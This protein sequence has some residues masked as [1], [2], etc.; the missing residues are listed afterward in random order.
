[1]AE[2]RHT[3]LVRS[4][5]GDALN[6]IVLILF[7]LFMALP[8][9]YAVS[10]SLKPLEEI[11]IF[12][13]RFFVNNPTFD[14]FRDVF[15]L[16]GESWIPF[17]RYIFN[18]VFITLVGTFG[19]VIIASMCA[20][21]LAKHEFPGSKFI[22]GV[23]VTS[24]MFSVQVTAI[25][26]YLIMSGLNWLDTYLA[27][28]VPAIA[29]PLGLFLMKQ[30]MEQIPDAI[31]EAARIDGASEWTVFWNIAMPSVKPAWLTLIIFS[32]QDWNTV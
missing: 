20:Y 5:W 3:N 4:R 28:I 2:R 30:F 1:M 9:V 29:K 21:A 27:L 25:P 15:I 11:F 12:P 26:N 23:I 19:H 10:Q 6:L 8:L 13:P 24:L 7:G 31:L 22:F 18:T 32:F 17:S 14:N 16:M